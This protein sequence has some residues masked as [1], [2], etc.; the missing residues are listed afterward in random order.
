MRGGISR[1]FNIQTA[2]AVGET[3]TEDSFFRV[4]AD[5]PST[6]ALLGVGIF[7]LLAARRYRVCSRANRTARVT[8]HRPFQSTV[9][10]NS[11]RRRHWNLDG[12]P[13]DGRPLR[14]RLLSYCLASSVASVQN[15]S[16]KYYALFRAFSRLFSGVRFR[17]F[18][19]WV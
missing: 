6:M 10:P 13:R 12:Q 8:R 17:Q 2:G 3:F 15:S 18:R 7:G 19:R 14:C 16:P 4:T 5:T 11:V 9:Q 1:T